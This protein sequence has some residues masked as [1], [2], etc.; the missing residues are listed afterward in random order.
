MKRSSRPKWDVVAQSSTA[1][2]HKMQVGELQRQ[3][4]AER[5]AHAQALQALLAARTAG[6][7]VVRAPMPAAVDPCGRE[8]IEAIFSDV[9]G[10][11]HDPKAVSA[12]LGDLKALNPH[13]I[14]IGGDFINCGGFLAEHHTLGYVAQQ[15]E[16]YE[17]DIRM[18]NALLDRIQAAAPLAEIHY[19]EGNHEWRVERWAVGQGLASYKDVEMLRRTFAPECVLRLAERG[20]RYYRQGHTHGGCV[21]P[22]WV[23]MDKLF[24][25][26]KLS[27]AA[28]AA[29]VAL[30]KTAGN[31]VFFDT[32]RA[33]FKPTNL[34]G[35]GLISAWNPGCLCKRQPLYLNTNPSGWTHGYLVRFINRKSGA[36]QMVNITINEGRSYGGAMLGGGVQ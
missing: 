31:V 23:K 30:G 11:Q 32:H 8:M 24:Y 34:P 7:R 10:H 18:S 4:A 6:K 13:R 3:L 33:T 12:L 15:E 35:V 5:G 36:F 27:N 19:L 21:V 26:H 9:H 14:F 1:A 29:G 17:E 16:S 28:D 20:I 25:V 22:G 2:Q